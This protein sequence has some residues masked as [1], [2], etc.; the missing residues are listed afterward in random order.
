[1]VRALQKKMTYKYFKLS[2]FQCPTL[3][4][5]A[6]MCPLFMARIEEAREIANIPFIINSGYRTKEHNKAVGGVVSSSHTNKPCNAADI[7]VSNSTERYKILKACLAAGFR[8][9]GIGKGF[10]HIDT[11][12]TNKSPDV[13]WCYY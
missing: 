3:E 4:G 7:R 12:N 2:E 10:L 1:M 9:V 13:I 8:R 6:Y 5:D 11:D